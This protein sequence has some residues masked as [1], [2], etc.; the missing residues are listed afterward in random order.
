MFIMLSSMHLLLLTARTYYHVIVHLHISCP[1]KDDY[2][3]GISVIYLG[4][5]IFNT[6]LKQVLSCNRHISDK[7][8]RLRGV[9]LTIPIIVRAS[10]PAIDENCIELSQLYPSYNL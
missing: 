10:G 2:F 5:Y 9:C 6:I 7:I 4:F 3:N 8:L 1:S